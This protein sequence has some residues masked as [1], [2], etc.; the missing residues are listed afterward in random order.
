MDGRIIS[1][2]VKTL[3][4]TSKPIKEHDVL[5]HGRNTT[6]V[7]VSTISRAVNLEQKTCNCRAWQ[8]TGKPCNHVLAIIVKLDRDVPMDDF[9]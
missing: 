9:V 3:N 5:L 7:T 4:A 8:V 1:Q 6:K 2:I